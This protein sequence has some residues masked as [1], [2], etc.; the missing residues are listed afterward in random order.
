MRIFDGKPAFVAGFFLFSPGGGFGFGDNFSIKTDDAEP[1][2]LIPGVCIGVEVSD[3]PG[4]G[5]SALVAFFS[6][7][8]GFSQIF[9]GTG[10]VGYNRIGHNTAPYGPEYCD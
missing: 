8:E 10:L 7:G 5:Y 6:G 3:I 1:A 4:V 9:G 2:K